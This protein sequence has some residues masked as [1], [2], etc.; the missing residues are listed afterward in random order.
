[1]LNRLKANVQLGL[2]LEVE[3][4]LQ[5]KRKVGHHLGHMKVIKGLAITLNGHL[6]LHEKI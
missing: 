5:N 6:E 4:T 1:M 3:A 2:V